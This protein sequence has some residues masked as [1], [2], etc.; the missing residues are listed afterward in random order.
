M[1]IVGV[2]KFSENQLTERLREVSMLKAPEVKV[3]SRAFISLERLSPASLSPPQNYIL[4]E[5]LKK[6]RELKWSLEEHGVDLFTLDG[7]VRLIFEGYD[8]PIDLL[9][10]I[11]EESIEKDGTVHFIINDGMHRVYMALREW[12]IPQVVL[13]RG[14][15]KDLPYYAYPIPGGWQKVEERDDLPAGFLKKWHRFPNYH[16]FYRNFNSAFRNVGG[17]RQFFQSNTAG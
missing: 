2:E 4:R 3:Y 17:P 14:I 12:V 16:A 15:P 1:K 6:V 7:F 10:P 9:P 13:I 5:E 11:V 8:E